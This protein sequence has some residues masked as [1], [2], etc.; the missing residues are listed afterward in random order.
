[1]N[2]YVFLILCFFSG[3]G[4][5][6]LIM[7][8]WALVMDVIDYHQYLTGRREEG[9]SYSFYSFARKI[10]QT[11][12]GSGAAAILGAIGYNGKLAVQPP[13][14]MTKLYDVATLIPAI[15]LALMFLI[16]TFGYQLS[17]EKLQE[18]RE[19]LA[20]QTEEAHVE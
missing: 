20:L 9:T 3:A 2:P 1:A 11:V 15:L 4:Q 7:E 13:E 17:K 5:T 10:G 16:L 8:I 12:A 6:F 14:V 19:N 18:M